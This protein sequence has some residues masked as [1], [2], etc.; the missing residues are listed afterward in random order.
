[1][2]KQVEPGERRRIVLAKITI[3]SPLIATAV[4]TGLV[5]ARPQLDLLGIDQD[6][7]IPAV[8]FNAFLA[9]AA[10]G[11]SAILAGRTAEE[12]IGGAIGCSIWAFMVHGFFTTLFTGSFGTRVFHC[13]EML[14][15]ELLLSAS[16]GGPASWVR[17]G[18]VAAA[19]R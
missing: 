8:I 9:T 11:I 15:Q 5:Y 7:V 12:K 19:T 1:M 3:L 17:T 4:S 14:S 10:S 13:K 2:A 18:W 16:R 6:I